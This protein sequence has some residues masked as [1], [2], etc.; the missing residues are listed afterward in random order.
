MILSMKLLLLF[1]VSLSISKLSA[2]C[3]PASADK[4]QDA[5]VLCSL[6]E[7]NGYSCQNADYS[8]PTGCTPLCPN[9]GGGPHLTS[10][11]AFVTK[12]GNVCITVTFSNCTVNNMGV[13]F[14]IWGDCDCS[15][16]IFC[17]PSCTGPGTKQACGVLEA[18]KT[19]YLF[20]EGCLGDVC[21]FTLTTSGGGA[22]ELPPLGPIIGPNNVCVGACS[23]K[24]LDSIDTKSCKPNFQWTLD[25]KKLNQHDEEI[26]LDF[27]YVG[28][29]VLCVTAVIGNPQSGSICDQ[30]GPKCITIKVRKE[31]D[32]KDGPRYICYENSPFFWGSQNINSS[33]EYIQHFTDKNC[34]EYDSI[35]NF[36]LLDKPIPPDIYFIS[37]I[38]DIYKDSLTGRKFS[39]CQ[40]KTEVFLPK[41]T[42]TIKC[43][44]S[45]SLTA[46]FL[47]VGASM[48][49]Y[50]QGGLSFCEVAAI[51]STCVLNGYTR[52]SFTYEWFEKSDTI[53]KLIGTGKILE[54]VKKGD[55]CCD[56]NFVVKLDKLIKKCTFTIC[57]QLN[58]DDL[59][60][61]QKCP[62]GDLELCL[63]D[64][65]VYR[66][67]GLFPTD[68]RHIWTVSGGLILT[69]NQNDQTE[70]K[71]LWNYNPA[72]SSEYIGL[73]CYQTQ[74]SCPENSE[75]C[76]NVKI[77][78][79]H[80]PNAGMDSKVNGLIYNLQGN[81]V[82][83]GEWTQVSGKGKAIIY[84]KTSPQ[85]K[86]KVNQSGKY[87]FRWTTTC[88]N[89]K[90]SDDV[91]IEFSRFGT[92]NKSGGTPAD[93]C[94]SGFIHDQSQLRSKLSDFSYYPNPV[95]SGLL[96][97]SGGAIG[98]V[99]NISIINL[100]GK[101]LF[102]EQHTWDKI[103]H[104][105]ILPEQIANGIY[106]IQISTFDQKQFIAKLF[107]EK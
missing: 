89:L 17:D 12:G 46:V 21:H 95:H 30:D 40:N 75:C 58:E 36:I 13:Q 78:N 69:N 48:R 72:P 1:L 31:K 65:G 2:K 99:T 80:I 105:I 84:N 22:P 32:R 27:L 70:I 100:Q 7:I 77:S 85:S 5:N 47:N 29:F 106:L 23:I 56:I 39:T 41:S 19:Y 11:W 10:W 83:H 35:V 52:D 57:E 87:Q 91:E 90:S 15:E 37:C 60:F 9:G 104:E 107:I 50:C 6:N 55:Y 14:G 86:I 64:T 98:L 102:N 88:N 8:N 33:G 53:K 94:C 54:L 67:D 18:C 49:E 76:I 45:Y 16:S 101:I 44:S 63:G 73:I 96:N 24:Y 26:K 66:V 71:V 61:E 92:S 34:C 68:V 38:G 79:N 20:V 97:I 4:C 28:D 59:K 3:T 25:G 81:L 103:N 93:T 42:N 43:D 51:D 62:K 74:G 82:P